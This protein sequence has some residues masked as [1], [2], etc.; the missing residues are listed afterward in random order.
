M[1]V[2]DDVVEPGWVVAVVELVVEE[3]VVEELVDEELVDE[4]LEDEELEDEE[5]LDEVSLVDDEDADELLDEEPMLVVV[6]VF[7]LEHRIT[8]LQ[9]PV[10]LCTS[11]S[12]AVGF[13]CNSL[14]ED[15]ALTTARRQYSPV[16]GLGTTNA[17]LVPSSYSTHVQSLSPSSVAPHDS[18]QV[19]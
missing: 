15:P 10:T 3:L 13:Q 1:L 6:D 14:V 12:P 5:L 2:D 17:S 8:W 18:H 16:G 9:S 11:S 19:A 7:G 4:E